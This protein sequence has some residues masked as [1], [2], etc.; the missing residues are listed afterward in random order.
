MAVRPVAKP[1][2]KPAPKTAP[3]EEATPPPAPKKSSGKKLLLAVFALLILCGGGAAWYFLGGGAGQPAKPAGKPPG[4]P[5]FVG[6]EPFTVNL[7]SEGGAD[8]YL[9]AV[10]V[11]R[12]ADNEVAESLKLYMPELRH[13][14]LLLLSG[15]KAS[16]ISSVAGREALA[17][18]LR[19]EANRIVAA[20]RGLP[21]RPIAKP[22]GQAGQI[23]GNARV[24]VVPPESQAVQS[25]LFTSF[26]VQ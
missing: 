25:V 8:Q 9:Q 21:A 20:A 5:V 4:P 1:A 7:Q 26:I 11:M 22:A 10:A 14:V 24:Q 23:G 3:A 16:D 13:R 18:E 2:A 15:K 17:E 19:T 6:L 12:V